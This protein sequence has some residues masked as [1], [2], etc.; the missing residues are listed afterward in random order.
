MKFWQK[1][2]LFSI[3]AFVLIFNAA[4]IMV[5]ERSHNTMLGQEINSALSQNM[6]I[7]SSVNA[8]V[9]ILRIYDSIDYEKTIL[10]N[11]AKEFV[12]KNSDDRIY[13]DI[14]NDTNRTIFSNTDFEMPTHRGELDKLAV[15]EIKYI[16]RDIDQR[17]ILFTSNITDINHKKYV[18]TYMKDVTSLYQERV[19]QYHFFVKVDMAACL[20]YMLIMFFVSRGLTKPIDR[21]NR[22][23]QVIAQGGFSERVRLKSKDEIGVLARNFNDMATVVEDTINDLERNNQEKQRFINNFTHELKTPLTSIIGYANFLRTTKYNEE[24]FVDG[25]NIIYS[26]G[27]RVESLSLK[28][29][30]LILLQENHFQMEEHDLGAIIA[31]IEPALKMKAKEKRIV[32]VTD[33]EEGRLLLEKDLIK[34]LIFNLVDNALKASA[35]QQSITICTYWRDSRYTLE[36]I[37]QGIGIAKEHRDKIFEPF[38]MADKARTKIN[39]GAGLGLSICQSVASIHHAVIEVTSK[40]NQGTT[41]GVIFD[42]IGPKGGLNP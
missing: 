14:M 23:A 31:E 6:S 9:P 28:L 25:L 4:S 40:E 42:Q 7:H 13:L 37:D 36:V 27:K 5:I 12:E 39:N 22:T 16:L 19:D 10:T 21:L 35:E 17:T 1:I 24:L 2:Y 11:I 29:M 15:E 8:I 3:L 33:C 34:V 32:I 30:D 20:L 38:Y 18:F 26:E 41:I